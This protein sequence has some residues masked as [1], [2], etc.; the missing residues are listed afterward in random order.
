M[1]IYYIN[2]TE[3]LKTHDTDFLRQ[4]AGGKE[5][6]S[7][8]RFTQYTIGR[9]LVKSVAKKIYNIPNTEIIIKNDKPKFKFGGLHFSISHSEDYVAAAFSSVECGL[10]IEIMKPRNFEA[11]SERYNKEFQT[12]EEFYEFWTKYE[13]EI[14]LQQR[15]KWSFSQV[16]QDEYMLAAVS[17]VENEEVK[18]LQAF[19]VSQD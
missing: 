10:D 11:L 3:F 17:S 7:L 4:Y 14:K 8:K 6:K 9:Y 2:T 19:G 13:A 18:I 1:E 16:F 12:E 5:F 15:M